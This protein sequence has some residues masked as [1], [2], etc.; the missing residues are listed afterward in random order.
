M[1]VSAFDGHRGHLYLLQNDT[2]EKCVG[3]DPFAVTTTSQR[4]WSTLCL[5]ER[6]LDHQNYCSLQFL[7][8][9]QSS[10]CSRRS[11]TTTNSSDDDECLRIQYIALGGSSLAFAPTSL[12]LLSSGS[13]S[14]APVM[15]WWVQLSARFTGR[16]PFSAE[17]MWLGAAVT[18]VAGTALLLLMW[19]WHGSCPDDFPLMSATNATSTPP[20]M[21][22]LVVLHAAVLL[23]SF[24]T[25]AACGRLTCVSCYRR[26]L[27]DA[28]R[29]CDSAEVE[30]LLLLQSGCGNA[31][32]AE[33]SCHP[34]LCGVSVRPPLATACFTIALLNQDGWQGSEEGEEGGG[35]EEEE[36]EEGP[37][38]SSPAAVISLVAADAARRGDASLFRD[39]LDEPQ[40]P[41][42]LLSRIVAKGLRRQVARRARGGLISPARLGQVQRAFEAVVAATVST[43]DD[44]S[45][46]HVLARCS[47]I[48][49]SGT[50]NSSVRAACGAV[51]CMQEKL[52]KVPCASQPGAV[53]YGEEFVALLALVASSGPE[54]VSLE[55]DDV[56]AQ[57][58]AKLLGSSSAPAAAAAPSC[59]FGCLSCII[60]RHPGL[61][62][63]GFAAAI[64]ARTWPNH[65]NSHE[66]NSN[67]RLLFSKVY[68]SM[69]ADF[70]GANGATRAALFGSAPAQMS[71]WYEGQ[72]RFEDVRA[73]PWQVAAA[74][75]GNEAQRVAAAA[76]LWMRDGNGAP[77]DVLGM[78]SQGV[79]FR[80][81]YR[82]LDPAGTPVAI[83]RVQAHVLDNSGCGHDERAILARLRHPNIV[84]CVRNR[85]VL[86]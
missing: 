46:A 73:A 55:H 40:A 15:M 61:A 22:L 4:L 26:R 19:N 85:M 78:G 50:T 79:V 77:A 10:K 65:Y 30:R 64:R 16:V 76:L 12:Y 21:S 60:A 39:F 31:H 24:G 44:H 49:V 33:W 5:V 17:L 84:Q 29:A 47:R 36:E 54:A 11:A 14:V 53:L 86:S 2:R 18:S 6:G 20:P 72:R 41:L 23:T 9:V 80:G 37:S 3:V 38:S 45:L 42:V 82:A 1:E 7:F 69:G 8:A 71:A 62:F 67:N 13:S 58:A 35:G 27:H 48:L 70:C 74:G 81:V 51:M 56:E 43:H 34:I 52:P 59:R 25:A 57:Q 32:R 75:A 63:A 68:D 28:I 66:N 83:K